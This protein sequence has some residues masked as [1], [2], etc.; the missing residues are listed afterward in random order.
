MQQISAEK[1]E[2]ARNHIMIVDDEQA[3]IFMMDQMLKSLGYNVTC[4]ASGSEAYAEFEKNPSCFGLIICDQMM[5][6]MTGI[7]LAGKVRQTNPSTPVILCTGYLPESVEKQ[8]DEAN[9]SAVIPKPFGM[10][11]MAR[12]IRTVLDETYEKAAPGAAVES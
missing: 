12:T 2:S 4:S 1:T 7:E 9:V 6:D 11:N 3:V 10:K 8:A 5:P